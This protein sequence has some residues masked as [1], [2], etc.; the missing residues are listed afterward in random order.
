MLC[1]SVSIEYAV[2]NATQ[3]LLV[4][5]PNTEQLRRRQARLAPPPFQRSHLG[6]SSSLLQAI[7]SDLK[8]SQLKSVVHYGRDLR[9]RPRNL[10][11]R[12]ERIAA[13]PPWPGE[14]EAR[15]SANDDIFQAN[16]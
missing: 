14:E 8:L 11:M 9:F 7:G 12:P 15:V 10:I 6:S 1:T 13:N 16:R 4:R 5:A 2:L 3:P